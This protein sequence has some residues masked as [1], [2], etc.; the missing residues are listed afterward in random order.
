MVIDISGIRGCA[1]IFRET[2]VV[3]EDVNLENGTNHN[4]LLL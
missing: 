3:R 1:N 2:F 4:F